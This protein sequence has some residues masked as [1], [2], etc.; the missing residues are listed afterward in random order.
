MLRQNPDANLP[1]RHTND[2]GE[3]DRGLSKPDRRTRPNSR[4]RPSDQIPATTRTA[5]N[6]M[7]PR[8]EARRVGCNRREASYSFLAGLRRS[9]ASP[10]GGRALQRSTRR[11]EP[12]SLASSRVKNQS[13]S[14]SAPFSRSITT[15]GRRKIATCRLRRAGRQDCRPQAVVDYTQG[16]LT[17]DPPHLHSKITPH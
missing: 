13:C 7:R 10:F 3:N 6:V 9:R 14:S 4:R 15:I 5:C 11:P 16:G 1:R 2:Q 17:N 8:D 12:T